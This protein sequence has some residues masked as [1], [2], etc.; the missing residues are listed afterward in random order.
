MFLH[1]TSKIQSTSSKRHQHFYMNNL[2]N[3]KFWPNPLFH[4]RNINQ[5]QPNQNH[6]IETPTLNDLA[7]FW[8]KNL[9]ILAGNVAI[10]PTFIQAH[11]HSTCSCPLAAQWSRGFS[12]GSIGTTGTNGISMVASPKSTASELHLGPK[13]A[14]DEKRGPRWLVV[15]RGWDG[16]LP[17]YFWG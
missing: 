14:R 4:I 7:K 6:H 1:Q 13:G 2:N 12:I 9:P 3:L 16:K 8:S 11:L 5:K 15:F 17:S 10:F